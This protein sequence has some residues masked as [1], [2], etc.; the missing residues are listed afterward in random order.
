ME[1][2]LQGASAP[3]LYIEPLRRL[4]FLIGGFFQLTPE[5]RDAF[6]GSR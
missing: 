3:A 1:L 6:P 2:A 5:V 4:G